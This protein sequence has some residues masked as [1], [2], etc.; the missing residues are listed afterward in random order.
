MHTKTTTTTTTTTTKAVCT[1]LHTRY[2]LSYLGYVYV[3]FQVRLL[4][5]QIQAPVLINTKFSIYAIHLLISCVFVNLSIALYVVIFTTFTTCVLEF[6]ITIIYLSRAFPLLI[7]KIFCTHCTALV[8]THKYTRYVLSYWDSYICLIYKYFH[9]I[10][11][12]KLAECSSMTKLLYSLFSFNQCCVC[13][14]VIILSTCALEF[15]LSCIHQKGT[16]KKK[17]KRRLYCTTHKVCVLLF[18]AMY[19]WFQV[20]L[21]NTQIQAPALVND[22]VANFLI[23]T[24]HSPS[25][26]LVLVSSSISSFSLPVCWSSHY[27]HLSHSLSL[28]WLHQIIYL[29]GM[30]RKKT[31]T[32]KSKKKKK[33]GTTITIT[34]ICVGVFSYCHPP[35][36]VIS[37]SSLMPSLNLPPS[38]PPLPKGQSSS[39]CVLE[40]T[41]ACLHCWSIVY[42]WVEFTKALQHSIESFLFRT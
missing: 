8:Y 28:S 33:K 35:P 6:P 42:L 31:R 3:W 9:W 19:V 20:C 1:A 12:F 7:K 23:H 29:P 15:P 27:H 4:N 16:K 2:V 21:L 22:Q 41:N 18:W 30:G 40:F 39:A 11:R 14:S 34:S 36:S 24:I 38:L 17:K 10:C 5:T 26:N 25:I 37:S 32:K 13:E